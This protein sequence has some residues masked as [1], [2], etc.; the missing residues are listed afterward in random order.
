MLTILN[1]PMINGDEKIRETIKRIYR[2]TNKIFCCARGKRLEKFRGHPAVTRSIVNGLTQLGTDFNIN[3]L[4]VSALRETVVVLSNK[5]ALKQAINLKKRGRISYLV[6]G[7]N[8]VEFSDDADNIITSK[9]I[10]LCIVPSLHVKNHYLK[11]SPSLFGKCEVWAA[12]VDTEYWR[13]PV[14][15]KQIAIVYLK[16]DVS[17]SELSVYKRVLTQASMVCHVIKYGHYTKESY[18]KSLAA[19]Y[20]MIVLSRS[21]SQGIALAEAWSCNVP[22]F[23]RKVDIDVVKKR[24]FISSSAPYLT[25][26]T[27]MFFETYIELESHISMLKNGQFCFNPRQWVLNNMS[28]IISANKLIELVSNRVS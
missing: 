12:G 21:E 5:S 26:Q 4:F 7:P 18:R 6:A 8:I 23:V 24:E 25:N 11:F 19:A 17:D 3:P 1:D 27:G 22:T 9:E 15:N 2:F 20:C 28:D 14:R 16:D 10:D 13:V